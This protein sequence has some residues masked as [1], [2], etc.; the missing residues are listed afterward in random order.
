M[1]RPVNVIGLCIP[2]SSLAEQGE[3]NSVAC[4]LC[5]AWRHHLL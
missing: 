4:L 1:G 5:C 2:F 3:D